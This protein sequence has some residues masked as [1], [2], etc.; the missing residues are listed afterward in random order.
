M[1]FSKTV[2]PGSADLLTFKIDSFPT[3]AF[4]LYKMTL[5]VSLKNYPTAT[6]AVIPVI[7]KYRECVPFEFKFNYEAQ[8][9]E[10]YAD[11]RHPDFDI[12]ISQSPCSYS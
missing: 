6:A 2:N 8:V 12:S 1:E 10:L 9:I 7:F 3:G 4:V 5:T 11:E